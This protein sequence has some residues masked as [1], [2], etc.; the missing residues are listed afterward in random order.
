MDSGVV[1]INLDYSWFSMS[2]NLNFQKKRNMGLL[3]A[4]FDLKKI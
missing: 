4:Q 3:W 2:Y 1:E